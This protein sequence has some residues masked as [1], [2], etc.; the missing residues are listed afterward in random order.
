MVYEMLV[1]PAEIPPTIPVVAPTVPA[2]GFVDDHVP[3]ASVLLNTVV[4]PTHTLAVP[5]DAGG[6]GFTTTGCV[7]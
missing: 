5:V 4:V 3:P 2:P 7:T 6:V 1:V